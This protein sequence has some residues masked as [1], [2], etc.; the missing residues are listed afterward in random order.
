MRILKVFKILTFISALV[1]CIWGLLRLERGIEFDRNCVQYIREATYANSIEAAK[2]NLEVAISYAEDH[3]LT[4]GVVSI[5]FKQPKNDIGYWYKNM[6][7]AYSELEAINENTPFSKQESTLID[8][9][10]TLTNSTIPD[11]IS[12]YP[13]NVLYFWVGLV[14]FIL[15]CVFKLIVYIIDH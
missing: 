3:N 15:M 9:R 14:S 11:G 7:E 8:I 1:F 12:I 5:F 10:E 13:N 4:E 2:E 6:T